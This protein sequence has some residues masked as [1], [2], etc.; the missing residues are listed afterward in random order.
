MFKYGSN[1]EKERAS[2][3]Q[4]EAGPAQSQREG[5]GEWKTGG[6]KKKKPGLVLVYE[7]ENQLK[8]KEGRRRVEGSP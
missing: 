3:N 4:R 8:N 7:E 5:R 6:S 1:A 2:K